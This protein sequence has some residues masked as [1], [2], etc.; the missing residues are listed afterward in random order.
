M[1][2][3]G[4]SSSRTLYWKIGQGGGRQGSRA[5]QPTPPRLSPVASSERR[6]TSPQSLSFRV[7]GDKRIFFLGVQKFTV[8]FTLIGVCRIVYTLLALCHVLRFNLAL[9][10]RE[11]SDTI[12]SR[13]RD[14][15]TAVRGEGEIFLFFGTEEKMAPSSLVWS[16]SECCPV[17]GGVSERPCV[18]CV[19]LRVR[20]C[21]YAYLG[22]RRPFVT[23]AC[24]VRR[25]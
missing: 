25:V 16:A 7:E 11:D 19:S 20:S 1:R 24:V 21:S 3:G 22:Q 13:F 23:P 17:G 6:R 8:V 4:G 15:A 12:L 18:L 14:R 10:P 2:A 9:S 5:G